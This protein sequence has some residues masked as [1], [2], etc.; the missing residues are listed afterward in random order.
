MSEWQTWNPNLLLRLESPYFP[1]VQCFS[2]MG[3]GHSFPPYLI[4]EY[5]V[6]PNGGRFMS[7]QHGNTVPQMHT[8]DPGGNM[9]LARNPHDWHQ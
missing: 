4:Q 8:R 2:P 6:R 1:M 5:E 3:W 7:L 9:D